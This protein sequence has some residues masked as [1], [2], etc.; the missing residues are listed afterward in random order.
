MDVF[1][2]RW[3][4][5]ARALQQRVDLLIVVDDAAGG[6]TSKADTNNSEA[7]VV[8][9]DV[10]TFQVV[11]TLQSKAEARD[12]VVTN[13][14]VTLFDDSQ[15][16]LLELVGA[17]GSSFADDA[18]LETVGRPVRCEGEDTTQANAWLRQSHLYVTWIR[19][20]VGRRYFAPFD[21]RDVSSA[22]SG[23][24][25]ASRVAVRLC[26]EAKLASASSLVP[27]SPLTLSSCL[28]SE[29]E[30]PSRSLLLDCLLSRLRD[31]DVAQF[32][33]VSAQQ[34]FASCG[35]S[36]QELGVLSKNATMAINLLRHI[37]L[38]NPRARRDVRSQ[39]R[40][41]LV[42]A[43]CQLSP[44]MAHAV[45]RQYLAEYVA[46]DE[47]TSLA[48]LEVI[49]FAM[50]HSDSDGDL[51]AVVSQLDKFMGCL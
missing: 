35:F 4:A 49:A 1:S 24:A 12:G 45:L 28:E 21:S 15:V 50:K 5:L 19:C 46:R 43:I 31:A 33:P 47:L 20:E 17:R 27:S 30:P 6:D 32:D 22:S 3:S 13:D 34:Q 2:P 42:L 14:R 41:G 25:L 11:A 26:D 23:G 40:C 51:M 16:T 48:T 36:A 10:S 44:L 37:A 38:V 9:V 18:E 29:S 39:H 7:A 8:V